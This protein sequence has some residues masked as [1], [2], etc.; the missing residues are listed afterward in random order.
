MLG[1]LRI[2]EQETDG[3]LIRRIQEQKER[4]LIS[5]E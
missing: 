5:D 2:P 3:E 4:K 1:V